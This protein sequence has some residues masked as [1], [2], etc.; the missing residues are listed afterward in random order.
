[1]IPRAMPAADLCPGTYTKFNH[2]ELVGGETLVKGLPLAL[3]VGVERGANHKP[4]KKL[5]LT[6]PL[7]I[8]VPH[9]TMRTE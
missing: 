4:F 3:Q 8:Y 5:L 6:S 2:A 9:G 7:G 1:M